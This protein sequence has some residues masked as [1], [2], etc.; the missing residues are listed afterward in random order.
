V[1]AYIVWIP[2]LEEDT[3]EAAIPSVRSLDDS[4]IHHFYDPTRSV[5][6]AIAESVKWS[7]NTAWD[8]YL[9]YSPADRWIEKAPGPKRWMHQLKDAWATKETYRTGKDLSAELKATMREL[10]Y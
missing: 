9:F 8:I 6:K 2:I 4:R 10:F 3:L 7:D 5:G 1:S